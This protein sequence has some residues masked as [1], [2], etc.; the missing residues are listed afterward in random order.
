MSE[1]AGEKV[2]V[3]KL[4][5][6]QYAL[7]L[8]AVVRVVSAVALAPNSDETKPYVLGTFQYSKDQIP[9]FDIR[10]WL[11]L[12]SKKLEVSDMG[13]I[14]SAA[15][16][17]AACFVDDASGVLGLKELKGTTKGTLE[18][19]DGRVVAYTNHSDLVFL[20][21]SEPL[22]QQIGTICDSNGKT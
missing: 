6:R 8:S 22:M 10:S 2:F 20:L 13:I 3:C 11:G 18:V 14:I 17:L 9:V 7:P 16:K 5:G 1:T 12:S 4:D 21:R 19:R 15:G